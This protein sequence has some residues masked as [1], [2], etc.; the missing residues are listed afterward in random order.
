MKRFII[1][2][3]PFMVNVETDFTTSFVYLLVSAVEDTTEY[4]NFRLC[5]FSYCKIILK[6]CKNRCVLFFD[7]D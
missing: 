3:G 2:E 4:L 6:N 7:A 1:E 5:Y